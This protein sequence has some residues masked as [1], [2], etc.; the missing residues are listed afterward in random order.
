MNGVARF[1]FRGRCRMVSAGKFRACSYEMIENLRQGGSSGE[2]KGRAQGKEMC[3]ALVQ[4]KKKT[5]YT[6]EGIADR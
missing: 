6:N 3:L 1:S 2:R 5:L 4:K